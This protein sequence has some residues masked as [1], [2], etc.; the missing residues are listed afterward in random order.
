[1]PRRKGP[2]TVITQIRLNHEAD[3]AWRRISSRL[4]LN[5]RQALET[6]LIKIDHLQELG[7]FPSTFSDLLRS[8]IPA[9]V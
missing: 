9:K 5:G 4:G 1:M 2:P 7:E 8:E 3:A 6:V